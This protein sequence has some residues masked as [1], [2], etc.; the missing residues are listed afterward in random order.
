MGRIGSPPA[1][2][3]DQ[4]AD[5]DDDFDRTSLGGDWH[6]I[7]GTVTCSSNILLFVEGGQPNSVLF[8][9]PVTGLTQY[10]KAKLILGGGATVVVGFIF[11]ASGDNGPAY[12]VAFDVGDDVYWYRYSDIGESDGEEEIAT[13][14]MTVASND[15]MGVT[16]E[17]TGNSTVVRIWRNPSGLPNSAT[18]WNGDTSPT[19]TLTADPA[20]PV[21][22]GLNIGVTGIISNNNG[23]GMDDW[24]GG[25]L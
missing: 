3:G 23:A 5:W 15:V 13:Q 22:S 7:V 20:T 19:L 10:Q 4:P 12:M 17:G 9:E 2:A 14:G 25:S 21:N 1:A 6:E 8:D 24:F 11:R 16:I 18:D